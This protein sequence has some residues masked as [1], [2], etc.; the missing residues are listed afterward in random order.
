MTT[1]KYSMYKSF[2]KRL[3]P[4]S[5]ALLSCGYATSSMADDSVNQQIKALQTQI[6]TA[7]QTL[8]Q[9]K[10]TQSESVTSDVNS[11]D[12][13]SKSDSVLPTFTDQIPVIDGFQFNGYF[14]AGWFTGQHGA[15]K[16]YA[17]GSLGR[18]GNEMSGWYDLTFKQRVYEQQGKK[19]EAVI[20]L[21]GNS[22]LNKGFEMEGKEQNIYTSVRKALFQHC[23][24]P[25]YGLVVTQFLVLSSRCWIG[26]QPVL[27]QVLV[28]VWKIL[29]YRKVA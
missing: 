8:Q 3:T 25:N 21:D 15:P 14:R 19:V 18:F 27:I 5:L 7:Q 23:L 16:E 28:S 10:S 4:I 6:A 12:T 26:K 29:S 24:K 13:V 20:T 1:Q 11:N 9:L 2:K 22:G 17:I